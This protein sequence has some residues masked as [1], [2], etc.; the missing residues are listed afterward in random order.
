MSSHEVNK[1]DP[2]PGLNSNGVIILLTYGKPLLTDYV[3]NHNLNNT[4]YECHEVDLYW[5][6]NNTEGEEFTELFYST[7]NY[8]IVYSVHS[9]ENVGVAKALNHMM[10]RAFKNGA[11]WVITMGNDIIEPENWAKLRV[12][13]ATDIARTGACS[14]PL[15]PP[16]CIRWKQHE[17]GQWKVEIGGD[18]IGNYLITRHAWETIGVFCEDYGLHGP[19]DLD[20]C[21]RLRCA[22][23]LH[24]YLAGFEAQ[25]LGPTHPH[26]NPDY[27]KNKKI[28]V[29]Q[30]WKTYSDNQKKYKAGEY[31]I[32]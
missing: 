1:Q 32:E 20:Y 31:Y 10:R 18:I 11:P 29:S 24:Y 15:P 7:L 30:G 8:R 3:W 17:I 9:D 26:S 28:A 19:V 4:G 23:L 6:D 2:T 27:E 13:A 21:F 5:W 12:S 16:G 14:I 22:E 25:H